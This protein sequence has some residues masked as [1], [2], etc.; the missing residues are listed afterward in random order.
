ME[1]EEREMPMLEL[2]VPAELVRLLFELPEM[3]MPYP[4]FVDLPVDEVM[5]L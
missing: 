3:K 1:L 5:V 4:V 2:E